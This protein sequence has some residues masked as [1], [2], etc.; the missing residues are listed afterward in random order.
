[1]PVSIH[2]IYPTE[3][4]GTKVYLSTPRS[5]CFL[6]SPSTSTAKSSVY[7]KC[8]KYLVCSGRKRELVP[9]VWQPQKTRQKDLAIQD[10]LMKES[11]CVLWNRSTSYFSLY[12]P[13][14]LKMSD[15]YLVQTF[16]GH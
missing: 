12:F 3:C 10:G 2:L 14:F 9:N 5:P 15:F 16:I 6:E 7:S 1:L 8:P 11:F 13:A 4:G